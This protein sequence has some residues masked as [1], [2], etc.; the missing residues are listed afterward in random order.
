MITMCLCSLDF[1]DFQAMFQTTTRE[2]GAQDTPHVRLLCSS[3]Q[4]CQSVDSLLVPSLCVQVVLN[5]LELSIDNIQKLCTQL[6]VRLSCHH[7][8]LC[9]LVY[10]N[11]CLY[12]IMHRLSGPRAILEVLLRVNKRSWMYVCTLCVCVYVHAC[13]HAY[14]CACVCVW[15]VKC[16]Y[17]YVTVLK[18]VYACVYKSTYVCTNFYIRTC[19]LY[20]SLNTLTY[21]LVHFSK[22]TFIFIFDTF[23]AVWQTFEAVWLCLKH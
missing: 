23:R 3:Y 8:C 11:L 4:E 13:V 16:I 9:E 22:V 5:D 21:L 7:S 12:H 2:A 15:Y 19:M 14:M 20:N 17:M 10:V 1:V 6:Q 18:Y